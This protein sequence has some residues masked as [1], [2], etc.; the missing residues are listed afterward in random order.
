MTNKEDRIMK[1]ELTHTIVTTA[2]IDRSVDFCTR[3]FINP[4]G[5][6]GA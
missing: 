2:H 5:M 3:P 4:N 6:R 1:I